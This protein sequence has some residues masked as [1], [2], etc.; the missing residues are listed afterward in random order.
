MVENYPIFSP[1]PTRQLAGGVLGFDRSSPAPSRTQRFAPDNG[2][3][4][5]ALGRLYVNRTPGRHRHHRDSRSDAAARALE[6]EAPGDGHFLHEQQQA[7]RDGF[8]H[9]D[10]RQ[11]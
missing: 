4:M 7:T 9:V 5:P 11:R 8:H 10:P 3:A 1:V 6:S 2:D